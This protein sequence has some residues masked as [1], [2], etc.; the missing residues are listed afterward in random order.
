MW[1]IR[2]YRVGLLVTAIA[3]LLAGCGAPGESQTNVIPFPYQLFQMK[4]MRLVVDHQDEAMI[5]N[6]KCKAPAKF[7][8]IMVHIG[9]PGSDASAPL[10]SSSSEGTECTSMG[11]SVFNGALAL[12][13]VL[14]TGDKVEIA[15]SATYSDLSEVAVNITFV[16]GQ[17]GNLYHEGQFL[18]KEGSRPVTWE[19][20]PK[21]L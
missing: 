5:F 18:P 11:M 4:D 9:E 2:K 12:P 6:A 15:A 13:N 21:I 17:D 7:N 16:V 10:D 8:E 1:C 20:E 3:A 14:Q 19:H